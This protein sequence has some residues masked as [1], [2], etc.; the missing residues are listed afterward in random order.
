MNDPRSRPPKQV[1]DQHYYRRFYSG[2]A[3]VHSRASVG[4]LASAVLGLS[5]WWNLPIRSVLDIGAGPG[6]WRDW[7]ATNHP[8]IRYVSTDISEYA[9]K[10]YAHVQRDI[11]T[12]S[13]A[14]PFD[15]VVCQGVLQYLPD[16]AASQAIENLKTATSRLLYLEVPTAED[17]AA[18]LDL[19]RSDLEAFWRSATWYR[20]RLRR[21]F[22]QV[23]A[24][25]WS[26]PGQL[27]LYEM[28]GAPSL[29]PTVAP[30]RKRT[31]EG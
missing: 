27:M 25:L 28:E 5:K 31:K 19:T 21:H 9:C 12:W 24:G 13:P 26:R 14:R 7:F 10:R 17:R 22:N 29:R 3:A 20:T 4:H 15:L 2:R 23:G 30:E 6:Y 16:K 11:G 1:F 18:T 8:K